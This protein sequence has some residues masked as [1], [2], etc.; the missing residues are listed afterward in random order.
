MK[1]NLVPRDAY[2]RVVL[3]SMNVARTLMNRPM[4]ADRGLGLALYD[5]IR[6]LYDNLVV[7]GL[8]HEGD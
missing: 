4:M 1:D 8:Y 5:D 7:N 3:R 6:V 2:I